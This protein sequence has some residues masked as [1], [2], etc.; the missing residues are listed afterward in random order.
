VH[1]SSKWKTDHS[2][3]GPAM[4]D[5]ATR[6]ITQNV[7]MRRVEKKD[8]KLAN[9]EFET[10]Y[11]GELSRRAVGDEVGTAARWPGGDIGI[12]PR[13]RHLGRNIHAN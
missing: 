7:Y 10:I 3:K 8:G 13:C 4:I 9:V 12:K 1:S 11:D 2:P 5:P 6:Q